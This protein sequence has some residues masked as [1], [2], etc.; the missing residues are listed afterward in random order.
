MNHQWT[1]QE[2]LAFR[3]YLKQTQVTFAAM[4]GAGSVKT[5]S[6]WENENTMPS[7]SYCRILDMVAK[8]NKYKL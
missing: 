2:V 7:N 1:G 4:L 6:D 3:N 8:E 5:I